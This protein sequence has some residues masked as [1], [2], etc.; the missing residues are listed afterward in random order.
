[1]ETKFLAHFF[2]LSKNTE[3]KEPITTFVQGVYE[4][5]S[6]AR[7]RFKVLLRK[8]LNHNFEV[9]MQL[10]SAYLL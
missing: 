10:A 2:Q 7:E 3:A 5:L 4:S 9:E 1:M 6:E 8:F